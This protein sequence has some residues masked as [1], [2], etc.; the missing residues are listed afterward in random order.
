[1][2]NPEGLSTNGTRMIFLMYA[3]VAVAQD[4]CDSFNYHMVHIDF[5]HKM[6]FEFNS[7]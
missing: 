4:C 2:T 6:D 5:A 1:M 7:I 3:T